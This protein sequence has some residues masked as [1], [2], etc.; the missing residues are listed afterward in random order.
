I[1]IK[2][3]MFNRAF[4]KKQMP[5]GTDVTL[6]GKWDAHRLQ[7]TVSEYKLGVTNDDAEIKTYYSVKGKLSAYRLKLFIKQAIQLYEDKIIETLPHTYTDKYKLPTL[8]E[9][10]I[11]MHFPA[12][13]RHLKQE[14][15]RFDYEELLLIQIKMQLLRKISRESEYGEGIKIDE[16]VIN[17]FI[18]TF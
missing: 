2:A 16:K 7:I 15:R 1:A 6:T 8:N 14:R 18:Q 12:S 13:E 17:E 11:W 10:I 4:A 3:V 9:E 5:A